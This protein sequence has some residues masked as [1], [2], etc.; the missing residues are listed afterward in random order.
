MQL[1]FC[2]KEV[3][4]RI[5]AFIAKEDLPK[6]TVIHGMEWNQDYF[7]D[8][9]RLLTKD[10]L[11]EVSKEYPIIMERA[12]GHIMTANFKALSLAGITKDTI[13]VAGDE[14]DHDRAGELTDILKENACAMV[15]KIIKKRPQRK[16]S[17]L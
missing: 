4:E 8:E 6:D 13:A 2:K 5:R 1:L 10:D 7:T 12:C 9:R 16:D 3:K 14:I 17:W 15:K 11:D